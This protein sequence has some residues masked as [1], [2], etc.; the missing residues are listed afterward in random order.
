MWEPS[1]AG[2]GALVTSE[3]EKRQLRLLRGSRS[4]ERAQVAETNGAAVEELRKTQQKLPRLHGYCRRRGSV[5]AQL[6]GCEEQG[7]SGEERQ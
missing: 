6:E 1:Q 3:K 2:V 7:A 5:Q 4:R